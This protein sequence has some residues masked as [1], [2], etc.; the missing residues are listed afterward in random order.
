MVTNQ[1]VE[2][3]AVSVHAANGGPIRKSKPGAGRNQLGMALLFIAPATI[4]F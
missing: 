2:I 1:S 4:G 3:P